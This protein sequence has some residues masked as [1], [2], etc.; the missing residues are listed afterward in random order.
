[1]DP[2]ATQEIVVRAEYLSCGGRE[3]DLGSRGGTNWTETYPINFFSGS[4]RIAQEAVVS[5][6]MSM[7]VTFDDPRDCPS[8]FP[9]P[10]ASQTLIDAV[11]AEVMR[12]HSSIQDSNEVP[13]AFLAYLDPQR[14]HN[15][16]SSASATIL[17]GRRF[18][19]FAT[20]IR[21]SNCLGIVEYARETPEASPRHDDDQDHK[22]RFVL[23]CEATSTIKEHQNFGL[24]I[25]AYVKDGLAGHYLVGSLEQIPLDIESLFQPTEVEMGY[26]YQALLD[27]KQNED[28]LTGHV[29]HPALRDRSEFG[30][31]LGH[32]NET[33][34]PN[35]PKPDRFFDES[36]WIDLSR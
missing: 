13:F 8:A 23:H 2:G 25:E 16:R 7:G 3:W 9:D 19:L 6:P 24:E 20:G 10:A 1:M 32:T 27:V 12:N 26:V 5:L 14:I 29:A 36:D 21:G 17:V 31:S 4:N 15:R 30:I 22:E 18:A 28:R 34:G 35:Q 11:R 33:R